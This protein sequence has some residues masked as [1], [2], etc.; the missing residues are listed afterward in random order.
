MYWV[1]GIEDHEGESWIRIEY[2]DLV[3]LDN[4]VDIKVKHCLVP[5]EDNFIAF[6]NQNQKLFTRTT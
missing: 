3:I 5:D 6:Y 1:K 2:F 4:Y